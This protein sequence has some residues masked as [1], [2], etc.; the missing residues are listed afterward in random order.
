MR[1]SS[2]VFGAARREKDR[3]IRAESGQ[4]KCS[5]AVEASPSIPWR[6]D[7]RKERKRPSQLP[8]ALVTIS[9]RPIAPATVARL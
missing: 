2:P 8:K 5:A 9:H 1:S 3:A 7:F 4:E 6:G